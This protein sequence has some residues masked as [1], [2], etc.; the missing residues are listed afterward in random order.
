MKKKILFVNNTLGRAGAE[1]ALIALLKSLDPERFEVDFLSV[2]NR[3]ELFPMIPPYVNILNKSPEHESLMTGSGRK[4]VMK[5]VFGALLYKFYFI[6]HLPYLVN[7]LIQQIKRK[8]F[9]FDKLFWHSLSM[10][11]PVP[12][13]EYDLAVAFIEGSATYFVADRVRARKK[14]A[15]I[16][17]DYLGAGYVKAIDKRFYDKTDAIFVLTQQLKDNLLSVY[18]EYADKV[19][20]FQHVML[21][22]ELIE[23]AK[24]GKGF[25]DG[26][27]GVRILTV[28]RLHP[29]KALDVAIPAFARLAA[30]HENVRWYIVGE[31]PERSR[32]ENL[33]ADYGLE[34]RFILLGEKENPSPYWEQCDIYAQAT[35]YEGWSIALASALIFNRPCVVSDIPGNKA[36]V[37]DGETG[38]VIKLDEENLA[39]ALERLVTDEALRAGFSENLRNMKRDYAKDVELLYELMD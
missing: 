6:T 21:P 17:V 16:Q 12:D 11:I 10:R 39:A 30:V 13:K 5:S 14:A 8:Q 38:I 23:A 35:N 9:M 36:Q 4:F 32:I 19:G 24:K 20:T 3:G 15:F 28:A 7:N 29:N 27:T 18:P 31:G 26:Y 25:D 22:G 33:I 2:L 1:N 37:I 34:D